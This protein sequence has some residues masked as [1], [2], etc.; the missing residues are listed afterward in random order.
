MILPNYQLK[1]ILFIMATNLFIAIFIVLSLYAYIVNSPIFV[2]FLQYM[3]SD[4]NFTFYEE[5]KSLYSFFMILT[6]VFVFFIGLAAVF[7]SHKTA[8][9]LYRFNL[10]FNQISK[11]NL[12][13]RVK[14]RPDDELQDIAQTFNKM[15]DRINQK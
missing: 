1:F 13:P 10:I 5:L 15:M 12:E 7:L 2:E 6:L 14:L 8:G 9:P 11:D 3:K 4:A